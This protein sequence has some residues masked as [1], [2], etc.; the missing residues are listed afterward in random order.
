MDAFQTSYQGPTNGSGE[1]V[2]ARF[3]TSGA[4]G[5]APPIAPAGPAST[6]IYSTLYGGSDSEGAGGIAVNSSGE[7]SILGDTT[8]SDV[9][10]ANAF[11]SISN[12]DGESA[13]L[14]VASFNST[15]T[16]LDFGSYLGGIE[17]EFASGS[18]VLAPNGDMLIAAVSGSSGLATSG[19]FDETLETSGGIPN[20]GRVPSGKTFG[21]DGIV[22]R[23][24]DPADL[25]LVV[26]DSSDLCSRERTSPTASRPRI[27]ERPTPTIR[28][29]RCP[30]SSPV[31]CP[32]RGPVP[33][34]AEWSL[35][36]WR[37]W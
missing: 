29:W 23:I 22:A 28:R 4:A 19:S 10:L 20:P 6:L 16:A 30:F 13:D 18:V 26:T 7:A 1:L 17:N 2:I 31:S 25:D 15:G 27:W 11:Q 9:V 3:D 34:T 35:V 5:P 37:R 12:G 14:L 8:S 32:R 36:I 24:G 33:R 21:E